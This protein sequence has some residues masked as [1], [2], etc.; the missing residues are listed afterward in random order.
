MSYLG[1]DIGTTGCKAVAF[2]DEGKALREAYRE[3]PL[4]HPA[5]GHAELDPQ[6][7]MDQCFDVIRQVNA[8]LNDPVTAMCI[9]SQGEAF[10]AV[11]EDGAFLCDAMVSSDSRAVAEVR[12]FPDA[13][14]REHLYDITGHTAHSSFSLFKLLWLKKNKHDVW[15]RTRYFLCFEDLLIYKLNLPPA[16]S[17]PLAGRTMLFDVTKHTWSGEILN[18]IELDEGRLASVHPSGSVVGVIPREA[19]ES[20]GFSKEVSVVAGGH[21]QVINAVGAGVLQPGLCMYATGTVECFCPMFDKQVLSPRLMNQNLCC[22]DYALPDAYATVAYNITGGNILKWFRDELGQYETH[23]AEKNNTSVYAELLEDLP[24]D[25]T[26]L[27]VLPY[28]AGSGT[29][30]F[31]NNARGAIVGLQLTTTK[32]EIIKALLEGITLEMRFNLEL[33]EEAGIVIDSFLAGGGAARND[34][35]NQIKADVLNKPVTIRRTAETGCFGAAMLARGATTR[36]DIR[37]LIRRVHEKSRTYHPIAKNAGRYSE[38][39]A[40][41]KELYPSLKN[42]SCFL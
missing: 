16:I 20:L 36:T 24:A 42:T 11:G 10:T 14:G 30:Y 4:L 13:F 34:A 39:Y 38:I 17:W 27:L 35:W 41:Y 7:V 28:F 5:A 23:L 32:K 19:A 2:D 26:S 40:R 25:P 29:P 6:Y 15:K 22:Y 8:S 9:S 21:D 33:M 1:L 18:H 12:E 31:D 3:Y 37:N